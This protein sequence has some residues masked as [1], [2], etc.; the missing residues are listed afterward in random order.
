[1]EDNDFKSVRKSLNSI[2]VLILL[3][4]FSNAEINDINFLGIKLSL[5]G[6]NVYSVLYAI[7]SYFTWRFL[8]KLPF[9]T[10]FIAGFD[11]YYL[12]SPNGVKKEYNYERLK[13]NFIQASQELSDRY[14]SNLRDGLISMSVAREKVSNRRKL[15]FKS[16]YQRF[17]SE[18][19]NKFGTNYVVTINQSVSRFYLWRKFFW[20]C[21]KYDK[22][23]DHIFPL[24][25]VAINILLVLFNLDWQGNIYQLFRTHF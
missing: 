21:L 20:Y 2:S 12:Q 10:Q 7:Y 16:T 1:M 23:G 8:T 14:K 6:E 17:E 9:H 3:L 22:F 24:F 5:T 11:D 13:N 15:Q 19:R 25:L 4:S 18:A